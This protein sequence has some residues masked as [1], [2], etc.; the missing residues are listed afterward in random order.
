MQINVLLHPVNLMLTSLIQQLIIRPQLHRQLVVLLNKKSLCFTQ[1]FCIYNNFL[2]IHTHTYILFIYFF[3]F[4][5]TLHNIYYI[6]KKHSFNHIVPCMYVYNDI[7]MPYYQYF[8]PTKKKGKKK[9]G[10][11]VLT[12]F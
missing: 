7:I 5:H 6:K 2:I 3:F 9:N 10:L 4:M 11:V 1:T 8:L 12:H